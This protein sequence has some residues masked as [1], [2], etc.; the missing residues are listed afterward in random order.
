MVVVVVGRGRKG[1]GVVSVYRC[2]PGAGVESRSAIFK[3]G[4]KYTNSTP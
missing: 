4:N 3:T 2:Q 1:A